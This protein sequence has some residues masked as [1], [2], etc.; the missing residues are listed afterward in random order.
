MKIPRWMQ[1]ALALSAVLATVVACSDD[2]ENSVAGPA[3]GNA[4]IRVIH[5][6]YDAPAVDI[7]VDN[8]VGINALAFGQSSGYAQVASGTRNIQ[9]V[10]DGATT[11]V[12]IEADLA[13]VDG[14]DYTVFAVGELDSI[15][16][17]F[18]D[19]LRAP[20]ANKAKVR[21]VHAVPDAPAVDVKLNSGTGPSL[22][23]GQA[24]KGISGYQQ[25]DGGAY[26]FA[27]TANG[28]TAEVALYNPITVQNGTVYTVLAHGTLDPADAYPFGVRIFVDNGPGD[29]FVDLVQQTQFANV[30]VIH[31][32]Y[33]APNVDVLIDD[34]TPA[35]VANLAYGA[36]S[37][38]AELESGVRNV[39][40]VQTGTGGP[41]VIEADLTLAANTDY[42]VFA[43]DELNAITAVFDADA[44]TPD[45]TMARLR[46]VHAVP[47]AP[48]VDIKLNTG[49]GAT[50]FGNRAFSSISA[51]TS[52]GVG[53][54]TFVVTAANNVDVVAEFAPVA[55][56][57][58]TVY[59]VVAH[60]TLDPSDAYPFAVRV[61]VDNGAGDQFVD[62]VPQ[63]ANVRVIHTSY[64]SPNVDVLID[65]GAATISDLPY[66]GSSGYAG[67]E[68]GMR[69]VKVVQTGTTAP[70][71]IEADL[72]LAP[73]TDYTVLAVDEL[74]LITAIFDTDARTPDPG[75]VKVR[76]VHTAPDAPAVDIKLNS[77]TGATVFADRAFKSISDYTT[78]AAGDYSFAV[79]AASDTNVVVKFEPVTVTPGTVYTVVAHGTLDTADAYP[80]AV[81]VFVDNDPGD[82]FV[83]LVPVP[84]MANVRIIHASYDAPNV[85]VIVDDVTPAAIANLAYRTSSGYAE[86]PAGTRNVKVV[87]TGTTTPA[88]IDTDLDLTE[89]VDYTVFAMDELTMI[90]AVVTDD[91][92]VPSAT[93]SKVRFVH[94]S[95]DAPAVDI[96]LNT[97]VGPAVFTNRAFKSI[98]DYSAITPG[99]YTFAV[100]GTGD[101][102]EVVRFEP[103]TVDANTVYTVVAFGTLDANDAYPF[104]VRVFVDNGTG[105]QFVDL[106]PQ[107]AKVRI[108]HTSYDAPNVDVIV[109]GAT[110]AAVSNLPYGGSSGYTDIAPG[111]RNV[112]V[113][114]T[115]TISP[116][117]ITAD[118][119]LT[120]GTDYTVFAVD[121]AG[122]I[123]AILDADA[124]TPLATQAKVR[125]VHASPDAPAV[126]IKVDSGS[127]T[128]V[129]A[130][131]AF[132]TIS[133]YSA[134]AAGAYTFAVTGAGDTV[135]VV[136]FQ[137]VTVSANTVYTVVAHGTL[138]A[139][140]AYPFAVR[141]FVDNGDGN[142]FVDLIAQTPAG[143][144][145]SASSAHVGRQ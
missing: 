37:G 123:D 117:F 142:Q 57:A 29:Q 135:E 138:D 101:T 39:K 20:V 51:Y 43:I 110:P 144:S 63:L 108:I 61:F 84:P 82:A 124:R 107:L 98:S 103:I 95:P 104:G 126:D 75:M 113:V 32:S 22:F 27:V 19:D 53:S 92:R 137:P 9:V 115:G 73:G 50:V 89:N 7:L 2:D 44:R 52:V 74:S 80:F 24:F 97:G 25:V 45:L 122:L 90:D 18:D 116:A 26:T 106:V 76:F 48:A 41:A 78:V 64:D 131:R 21:F 14:A 16:A 55:V 35:A 4:N 36:S 81:R 100:T 141:V 121:E 30:R 127:G 54:Y 88:V 79:T 66:G 67:L 72:T 6:S 33:D 83:D 17:V 132:K 134:V 15:T 129:F 12:V 46:F 56:S 65:D 38:Y 5:A 47:D 114:E 13:L 119:P 28:S 70:A 128:A 10:P 40:V 143:S 118:L 59:T 136:R 102:V 86:I 93:Q 3:A 11:P 69:N 109:D 71:V 94:G 62:L 120:V 8:A 34:A 1:Q 130:N 140:D 145:E 111:L 125:F 112:Q 99:A 31:T 105:A 23:T 96:K 87:Q 77:G 85:D 68:P 60:G 58:G 139:N 49:S 133:T 42:T 91:A